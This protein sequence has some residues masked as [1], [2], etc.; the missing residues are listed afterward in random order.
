MLTEEDLLL[1]ELVLLV[2]SSGDKKDDFRLSFSVVVYFAR[3]RDLK[4]SHSSSP[5]E[6]VFT[7]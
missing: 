2:F 5:A 1:P 6:L 4:D 7:P 3:T